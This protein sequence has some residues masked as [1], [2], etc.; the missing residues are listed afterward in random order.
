[1]RRL[2]L[3]LRLLFLL[4]SCSCVMPFNAS[5]IF[6]FSLTLGVCGGKDVEEGFQHQR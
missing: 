4:L 1:M 3:L 5:I 2:L 6:F